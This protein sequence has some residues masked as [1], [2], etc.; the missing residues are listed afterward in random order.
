M[1]MGTKPEEILTRQA[2]T[3]PHRTIIDRAKLEENQIHT[4]NIT[5]K[6]QL[7][8]ELREDPHKKLV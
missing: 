4:L 6:Q 8:K 3:E 1:R 2:L 7:L 5:L